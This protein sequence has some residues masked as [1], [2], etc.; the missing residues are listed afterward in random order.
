MD[1]KDKVLK[2]TARVIAVLKSQLSSLEEHRS[3]LL[4]EDAQNH[5]LEH[6]LDDLK[7]MESAFDIHVNPDV[8]IDGK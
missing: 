8:L 4:H 2:R 3:T 7:Q 5:V 1:N 6:L